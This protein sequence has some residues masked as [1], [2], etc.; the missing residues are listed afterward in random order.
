M[1]DVNQEKLP[2][3]QAVRAYCTECLGLTRWNREAIEDCQGDQASCGP[4]PFYDYRLGKRISLKVFRRYCL[5][6]TCGDRIYVDE[7]PTSS[8]P[9]YPYRHGKNPALKGKRKSPFTRQVEPYRDEAKN[10]PVS[11]FP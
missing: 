9:C 8:C 4:C 5:Y 7:C 1:N 10:N 2:P 11:I 3:G 6:C